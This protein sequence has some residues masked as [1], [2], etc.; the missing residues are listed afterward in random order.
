ME[1]VR[2]QSEFTAS[3]VIEPKRSEVSL[4]A[5]ILTC[6]VNYSSVNNKAIRK[7]LIALTE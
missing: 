1:Q 4:L 7:R 5:I 2:D 6:F 3:G